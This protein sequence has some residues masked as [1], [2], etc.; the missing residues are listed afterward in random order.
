MYSRFAYKLGRPLLAAA[1]G[2]L[3]FGSTTAL[4]G[5]GVGGVFNLGQS[6]PVDGTTSL[7]G[8][9]AGTQLQVTNNSTAA[10]AFSIY[11]LINSATPGSG[12]TAVRGHNKGT[13]TAGY[14]VY[15][16]HAGEGIGVYGTTATGAGIGVLGRHFGATGS[17]PGVKG[18]N[19]SPSAA[20]VLGLNIG[21]GPGLSSVVNSGVAPLSVNS[22]TRVPNL[23]ADKVDNLDAAAFWKLGGNGGTTPGTSFLG[24]SDA[25][26]L[27]F[28]T[29]G[30]ERMRVD[31]AGLLGIGTASPSEKLEVAGG[32]VQVSSSPFSS[33]GFEAV[34]FPPA[35][36]TTG[37]D[38]PWVRDTTTF[39]EGTA[40]AATGAIGNSQSTFLDVDVTFPTAGMVR[41]HWKVSSDFS[42]TFR[43]C[44]DNDGCTAGSGF[45]RI[46]SGETVWIEVA[47]PVSAGA[48]SFRWVYEKDG[49]FAGF[50]DKGWVDDVRFEA[51]G[52]LLAVDGIDVGAG[53]PNPRQQLLQLNVTKG[54]GEG[55]RIDSAIQGYSPAIYLNHTGN[56]G[57]NFRIAS[58]GNNSMPGEF[59]IRDET[60]GADR[61][62]IDANGNAGFVAGARFEVGSGKK[63]SLGGNGDFEIDAPGIVAGRF[64]VT[65]AGNVGIGAPSP[66][67]ILTV[68]P[69]SDTD[70]IAD[71]WTTYSSRRWKTDIR[72][73]GSALG[74][75]EQLRGVRFSWKKTGKR[76]I[77]LI[78]E[79][80][81]RVLPRV[82]AHDKGGRAQG[83]DYSRLV[84][85]LIEG[86]KE[87]QGEL[88]ALRR[89]NA[90]L[91]GRLS[92]LERLVKGGGR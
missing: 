18:V 85:V 3:I 9:T 46:I 41:F 48:H 8:T 25:K 36:W 28:K 6:N 38:A 91:S 40:S 58:F 57:H 44:L 2:A 17:G 71:A 63:P 66:A 1:A 72:T 5:S 32:N 62:A 75:L 23:N 89:Q 15:G 61:M 81:D 53:V 24:T 88:R 73:I 86:V 76:D 30:A 13:G 45:E 43:F 55:M 59:V 47:I 51:G 82:V 31:P 39:F 26:D 12:S 68:Q 78:A 29:N 27:V 92:R 20:G 16:S 77:G 67:N 80:V 84:P 64:V 83:L 65:D 19:S 7:M 49:I 70:P 79:E 54:H 60:V 50:S 42:D 21:G 10:S 69:D 87:Q 56:Q 33:A 22:D 4:G 37:G 34:A 52:H 35:G 74:L 90:A 11:G 14:G